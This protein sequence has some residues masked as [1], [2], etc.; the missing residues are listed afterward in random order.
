[1]QLDLADLS[2]V[3]QF[4]AEV[5]LALTLTLTLTLTYLESVHGVAGENI[6]RLVFSTVAQ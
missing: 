5:A 2:S 1:M 6:G 4:A 3:V